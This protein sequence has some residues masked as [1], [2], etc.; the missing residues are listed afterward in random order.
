MHS[1]YL[2]R[3]SRSGSGRKEEDAAGRVE[4]EMRSY[5]NANDALVSAML[6][7][8]TVRFVRFLLFA[9]VNGTGGELIIIG[10]SLDIFYRGPHL[11]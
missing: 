9:C 1:A 7:V 2:G 5:H 11:I 4:N 8:D 6:V 10:R 3:P